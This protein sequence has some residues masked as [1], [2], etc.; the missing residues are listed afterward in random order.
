MTPVQYEEHIREKLAAFDKKSAAAIGDQ[1]VNVLYLAQQSFPK[2]IAGR[3]LQ[4]FRSARMF[5]TMQQLTDAF[6]FSGSASFNVYRQYAQSLIDTSNFTAALLVLDKLVAD[7]WPLVTRDEEAMNEYR[8]AKGLLGRLYKQLYAN[9]AAR[10]VHSPALLQK[11]IAAYDEIYQADPTQ[12]WHGINVVALVKRAEDD[13]IDVPGVRA[14]KTIAAAIMQVINEKEKNPDEN[15]RADVWDWATAAEAS[16]ALGDWPNAEKWMAF[17]AAD[18]KTDAFQLA[19]TLRQLE[20]IWKLGEQSAQ[21]K[22]ILH[23]LRAEL[24]KREGGKLVID[25]AEMTNDQVESLPDIK[26]YEKNF[27]DNVFINFKLYKKGYT[28]CEAIARIGRDEYKGEGTGFLIDGGEL[29]DTLKNEPV[30]ITN[31]HVVSEDA[32]VRSTFRALNPAEAVIVFEALDRDEIFHVAEVIYSSP[33][34]ELDVTVMRF[35][36]EELERLR[37]LTGKVEPYKLS[38]VLPVASG[39]A[40]I[41]PRVYVIGYPK[42]GPLQFSLQDNLLLDC[43]D[44]RIHYRTPTAGGSSGSPVF[45]QQWELLGVHHKG[46]EL[47]KKLNGKEGAYAANEG[48]YIRTIIQHIKNSLV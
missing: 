17:Y 22:Q 32:A 2:K 48:I 10:G 15:K 27:G 44:P 12:L 31:A 34:T 11:A 39:D 33:P 43:E 47:M 40:A 28:C 4:L 9:A 24:L 5:D 41:D 20:E 45:N 1:L 29:S 8:E 7:C 18:E 6:I 13:G 42:G 36:K 3:I 23:V 35:P 16:I 14:Y 19:G 25:A 37:A 38:R 21:A 46:D 30:L 26:K